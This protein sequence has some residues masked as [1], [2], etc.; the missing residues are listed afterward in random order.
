MR[1]TRRPASVRY[2]NLLMISVP[3]LAALGYLFWLG[4][5][6]PRKSREIMDAFRVRAGEPVPAVVLADTLGTRSSLADVLAGGPAMVV[7]MNPTCGHCHTELESL[8]AILARGDA[9]KRPRVVVVSVGEAQMLKDAA[10]RYPGFAVYDDVAGAIQARLGLRM[11]PANFSVAADGRVRDV[12]V[13]LQGE[14][15]L[16]AAL[17]ALTR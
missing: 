6:A 12:R 13:G 7:V 10:R 8:R 1:N 2:F 4:V 17:A 9:T 3:V 11:V 14:P 16:S 15:Y 5:I